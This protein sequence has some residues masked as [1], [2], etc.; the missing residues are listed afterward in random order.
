MSTLATYSD[1][2]GGSGGGHWLGGLQV[3]LNAPIGSE[4]M[5]CSKAMSSSGAACA[6]MKRTLAAH[7]AA[8]PSG[9]EQNVRFL[10]HNDDSGTRSCSDLQSVNHHCTSAAAAIAPPPSTFPLTRPS[11]HQLSCAIKRLYYC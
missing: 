6:A 11:A 3:K 1:T 4:R 7:H 10:C 2:E 8:P 9:L 5:R